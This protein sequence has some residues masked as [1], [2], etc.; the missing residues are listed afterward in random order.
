[1][2]LLSSVLL[3][4]CLAVNA[5]SDHVTAG[6]LAAAFPG[7]EALPP[8][9][10]LALAPAPGV[11]RVFRTP[12]VRRIATGLAVPVPAA[13]ICVERP[14]APLDPDA[15]LEILKKELPGASIEILEF[16]HRPVPAGSLEFRASGLREGLAGSLW[17]GSVR[18]G[19][20]HR[21]PIWARVKVMATVLRV[22]ALG[23]L[24]PGRAI[25]PELVRIETREEF[26]KTGD[27]AQSI[28]QVTG[29]WP[30]VLVHAG[31]EIR[32]GQ[33]ENPPDILRG[34]SVRV[35]VQ[36]G[37]AHLEMEAQAEGSGTTGAIITVRNPTSQKRFLAR[38][39]G[40]GKV[41][42][43]ASADKGNQ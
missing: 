8:E 37:A 32:A 17:T 36:N 3:A 14:V 11:T 10:P 4:G 28:D 42:V 6:A 5:V 31:A 18:Y 34:D 22:V 33:L 9:T 15:L 7:L 26:P 23:D 29:K 39:E 27:F 30:R 19:G 35:E 2:I 1:M 16:S 24:R 13:E 38:I 25:T 20:T 40:K 41:S 43:G 12:E 21:F